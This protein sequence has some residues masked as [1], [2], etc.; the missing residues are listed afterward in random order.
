MSTQGVLTVTTLG[1][2]VLDT[3]LDFKGGVRSTILPVEID[4]VAIADFARAINFL[5]LGFE[6]LGTS[7]K[8]G[9]LY[10]SSTR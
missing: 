2:R 5:I 3:G 4:G 1:L 9:L 10:E 6:K 8:S 7:A